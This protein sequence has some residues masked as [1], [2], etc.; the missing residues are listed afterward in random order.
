MLLLR[1]EKLPEG[2][3]WI[4]EIKLDGYRALAIRSGGKVRLRSRND[5]DFSA[6]YPTIV[7]GLTSLRDE[8]VID[9]EVAALDEAGRPSF[10]ALQ[11]Y[12]A[13]TALHYYVFDVLILAGRDVMGEPLRKRR[14]LLESQILPV[15]KEP[16]RYSMRFE[17]SLKDLIQSAKAQGLEGLVAKRADS[18][19]EPGR[20][21]GPGEKCGS[22]AARSSS[23]AAIPSAGGRS[24]RWYSGTTK[25]RS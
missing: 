7:E 1:T 25:G 17:A 19:Y 18:R 10:N 20:R 21:S 3:D 5:K 2:P 23:S 16:V 8:T 9:G 11:N 12:A 15:L 13:G 24:T 22:I 6:R 14:E 4:Y